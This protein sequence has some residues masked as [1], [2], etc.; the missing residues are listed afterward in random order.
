[1]PWR[2]PEAELD[3]AKRQTDLVALVQSRGIEL[4]KHGTRDF[5][6]RCPF[7][8]DRN[9]PN[10]IVTPGKG[11]WH[12]M[13]CGKAGNVIQFVQHHDGVSFRHAFEL[14][15]QGSNAVFTAQPQQ[16]QSTVPKLPCPLD[17]EADDAA[18]LGQVAGYYHERLKQSATA[19]AYLAWRGLDS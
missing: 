1:M 14:L 18:V 4:K 19:R 11:L 8:D 5:I 15:K 9:N 3:Q 2:I 17:A 7:H 13:A 10:F 12:C 16:K 6:G